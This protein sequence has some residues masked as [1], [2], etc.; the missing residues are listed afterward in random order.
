MS[1]GS[2]T[3]NTVEQKYHMLDHHARFHLLV[4]VVSIVTLYSP[5][6]LFGQKAHLPQGQ[7]STTKLE[8]RRVFATSCSACHGLDG[9][10]SERGPDIATRREVQRLADDSLQ[11]IV[12]DGV[13]GTGMPSFRSLGS[14][15]IDAVVR[16][17]RTLQGRSATAVLPG[18]P[19]LGKI[20]YF[21]KAEC[22]QCHMMNGDGG[23]IASDLSSYASSRSPADIR[24]AITD[25]NKNIDPKARI[26]VVTTADGKTQTGI[27]RNE[28]NFSLQLQTTDGSF[29]F[30]TKS[31]VRSIERQPRSLMPD[32]YQLRL[33][34][35]EID[36]L[37]SFLM[38]TGRTNSKDTA[39]AEKQ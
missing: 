6:R 17:L 16:Y 23:F 33:T 37:V 8:G 36:H 34:S 13:T 32:D 24:S 14:P 27:A 28:D 2:R 39:H 20:L 38:T 1:A 21:G 19:K 7:G 12:R 3:A 31:E 25:P 11:R 26:I 29:H 30:L 9:R 15:R 5:A 18:D 10:G 4:L 22:S 35:K